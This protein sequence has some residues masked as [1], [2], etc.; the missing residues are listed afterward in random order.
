M[1]L[2]KKESFILPLYSDIWMF[3]EMVSLP[4]KPIGF[5]T[6]NDDFRVF[7]G[8]HHLRKHPYSTPKRIL[9]LPNG[10]LLVWVGSLGFDRGYT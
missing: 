1:A 6:K 5:P 3:P 4:N 10:K 9:K 8:Y 2:Y 7:W